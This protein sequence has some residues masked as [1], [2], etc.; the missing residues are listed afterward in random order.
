MSS[1]SIILYNDRI[2]S[3]RQHPTDAR[4]RNRACPH[5]MRDAT[6]SPGPPP[7]D[8][9]ESRTVAT[10]VTKKH[11]PQKKA[12]PARTPGAHAFTRPRRA[13]ESYDMRS[14][15]LSPPR[16]VPQAAGAWYGAVTCARTGQGR[17]Q[18]LRTHRLN[19]GSGIRLA[20][21]A[22][23]ALYLTPRESD[24]PSEIAS[25]NQHPISKVLHVEH[26]RIHAW[27]PYA[28]MLATNGA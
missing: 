3:T 10:V 27:Y 22:I 16:P 28:C 9:A 17:C 11:C 6:N 23:A 1:P 21:T 18:R 25:T 15:G 12:V 14:C 19:T 26:T 13:D 5:G 24:T 2:A 20:C 8:F 7:S 4:A